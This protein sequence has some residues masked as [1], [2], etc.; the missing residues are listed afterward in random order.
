MRSVEEYAKY[1]NA[2]LDRVPDV[3]AD[4]SSSCRRSIDY[5]PPENVTKSLIKKDKEKECAGA[6]K[7]N[8]GIRSA[9]HILRAYGDALIALASDDL[10]NFK[11]GVNG[12]AEQ[13]KTSQLFS[14]DD[15]DFFSKLSAIVTSQLS[16]AYRQ[17]SISRLIVEADPAVQAVSKALAD[18]VG[19]IY[20]EYLETEMLSL[21]TALSQFERIPVKDPISWSTYYRAQMRD[22]RS[23]QDKS[24]AVEGLR[25]AIIDIGTTHRALAA[26]SQDLTNQE[27]VAVV[28]AFVGEIEPLIATLKKAF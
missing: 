10:V 5:F 3:A 17:R 9:A 25:Q 16:E 8:T 27:V 12:L 15:V 19:T 7:Q 23:L 11:G 1:S 21:R 26:N 2:A 6:D 28:R 14:Q 4:F 18:T 13:V 20:G 22:L 24:K